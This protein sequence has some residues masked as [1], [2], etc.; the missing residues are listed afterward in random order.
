LICD[1]GSARTSTK[2]DFIAGLEWLL[3]RRIARRATRRKKAAE[4]TSQCELPFGD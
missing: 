2:A 1:I 4:E 3:N